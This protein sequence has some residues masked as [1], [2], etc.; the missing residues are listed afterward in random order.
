MAP[1]PLYQR[2]HAVDH[3]V[4]WQ[5][6]SSVVVWKSVLFSSVNEPT[7]YWFQ[8]LADVPVDVGTGTFILEAVHPDTILSVSSMDRG[9]RHGGVPT[10][11]SN[12]PFPSPYLDSF[13]GYTPEKMVSAEA[14]APLKR[15]LF[16]CFSS[17]LTY[18]FL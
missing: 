12:V 10:P 18:L 17:S 7:T 4:L 5:V 8:R 14:V 11:P 16:R 15:A 13:Q 3:A 9:Q 1:V 2:I 6:P